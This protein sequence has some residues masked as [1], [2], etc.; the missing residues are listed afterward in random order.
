MG[1]V[2]VII[3]NR[4][5]PEATDQLVEKFLAQ[6]SG[7]ADVFV[8]ES[9]SEQAKLSRYCTWWA[10][11]PEALRTGLRYPRGFNY[12][13]SQLQRCGK[14][15]AYD[16]FF[17]VCN[18]IA[19]DDALVPIL[20]SEM[21]D[22]PRL[23]IISPCATNWAE[24][25]LIGPDQTRYVCHGNHLAWM[26]RRQFVETI[27][28]R[29]APDHMNFLY[30]GNNFRGYYADQELIIKAYVNEYAVAITT[31]CMINERTELLKTRSDL[32]R[33]DRYEVNLRQLFEEGQEWMR[34]KYGFNTRRQM[35]L[36]AESFY[37]RF[38]VAYP[39]LAPYRL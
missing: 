11:W 24:R 23:G 9:G 37:D 26:V 6:D 33:T 17:L 2:A 7:V 21:D 20:L 10:D 15:A 30:D 29:H 18:D 25:E 27:M 35:M 5:L 38:F 39:E 36:Y 1:R 22:H 14:F 3:L 32:I 16:H 12:G 31:K 13:L 8:V 4:N 34:R 28:E 19:F